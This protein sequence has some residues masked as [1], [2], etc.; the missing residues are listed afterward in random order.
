[1]STSFN[2]QPKADHAEPGVVSFIKQYQPLLAICG[3]V[4]SFIAGYAWKLYSGSQEMR[5][6]QAQEWRLALSTVNMDG[7][8]Q[9]QDTLRIQSFEQYGDYRKDAREVEV[10]I[11]TRMGDPELFD[12]AYYLLQNGSHQSEIDQLERI[13]RSLSRE[14]RSL[15]SFADFSV[16]ELKLSPKERLQ[17]LLLNPSNYLSDD[18]LI[19]RADVVIDELDSVS[20]GLHCVLKKDRADC[21][22][23][24]PT[25]DESE[26]M[27]LVNYDFSSVFTNPKNRPS[28]FTTC[29]V[30][31]VYAVESTQRWKMLCE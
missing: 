10:G 21:P 28:Y 12:R 9:L 24:H 11:L 20:G 29:A 16:E 27:I 14:I 1:M 17:R 22:S 5:E 13:D 18:R 26:E 23:L 3:C 6:K 25:G 19:N 15:M 4:I 31:T 2:A 7:P 30:Q 8:N